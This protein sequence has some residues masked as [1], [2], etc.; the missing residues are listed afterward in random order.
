M[1]K[2]NLKLI[3]KQWQVTSTIYKLFEYNIWWNCLEF[4]DKMDL[5]VQMKIFNDVKHFL[6][7]YSKF[8]DIFFL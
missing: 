6:A 3:Y 8:E 5:T 2:I 7:I 4:S 1:I